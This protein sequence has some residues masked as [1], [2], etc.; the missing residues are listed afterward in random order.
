VDSAGC[1]KATAAST[2]V[3]I[4]IL[5]G[6]I[7]QGV[8]QFFDIGAFHSSLME[9]LSK[10]SERPSWKYV[11]RSHPRSAALELINDVIRGSENFANGQ[12]TIESALRETSFPDGCGRIV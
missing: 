6:W 11:F 3:R 10:A 1:H 12:V 9:L 8:F 4:L 5:I 2:E 7:A